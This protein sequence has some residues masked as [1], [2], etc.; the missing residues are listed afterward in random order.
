MIARRLGIVTSAGL[1]TLTMVGFSGLVVW[2]SWTTARHDLEHAE[3]ERL[4]AIAATLALEIPADLHR[5]AAARLPGRDA[6]RSWAQAPPQLRRLRER[7]V[8]AVRVN[9]LPSPIYTLEMPQRMRARIAA[10][11]D[12]RWPGALQFI[13]TTAE[14]PY[15]RHRCDYRAEMQVAWFL[16]RTAATP[17]YR[18][19][20]GSWVSAF[21]PIRDARGT[22]VALLEVDQPLDALLATMRR[23]L[24]WRGLLLAAYFITTLAVAAGFVRHIRATERR[25]REAAEA[26]ARARTAFL[27]NMSHE[28]RTPLTAILGYAETL[29]EPDLPERERMRA[30]RILH[31]NGQHLLRIVDDILDMSRIE[32][33]RLAVERI[34][35]N[36]VQI[37]AEV[38]SLMR[39]R[40][41]ARQLSLRFHARGRLPGT[42][43]S[44]P[45]RLR[46]ILL[47][48]VGNAIKFTQRGGVEVS[49][50]VVGA[51]AAQP[52]LKI[53]VRDSGIGMNAEQLARVFEPFAQ[54]DESTTRR[55]GGTGLG[56]AISRRL[57]RQLGGDLTA[58]STPGRGSCFTLT[59]P[60]GPLEGVAWVTVPTEA[61]EQPDEPARPE[62]RWG[63]DCALPKGCRILLAEDA[64]DT[65]RLVCRFLEKGGATVTAVEDGQ[66]AVEQALAAARAGRPF[67]AVLMD[68]QMPV[69][70]GYGATRALREAGYR[71]TIIALTAH[72]MPDDRQRCLRAGCDDYATKPI[73][74][75]VLFATLR[76]H[77]DGQA[78][79]SRPPATTSS[80]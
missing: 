8:Q 21:A 25:R 54:A 80:A 51:H 72:A 26:G 56:L 23:R 42:I 41:A 39:L 1:L 76:R 30:A 68:M 64:P 16:G 10:Q 62:E 58:Q 49:A 28:I 13:L 11:P 27:A 65:R 33:G 46:Q 4:K 17:I 66:Q 19:A 7:L 57:A 55:F 69:L 77:L 12:R 3:R 70:D 5:R 79:S 18:D 14:A 78:R 20:H 67:D 36:P 34:A 74:R 75:E 31:R 44:D 35:C 32:S 37:L 29:S 52:V 43:R 71:G 59:I 60:T 47:N 15:W 6:L 48:L 2:V 38:H 45:T 9:H 22:T 53:Q 24:A 63:T 61:L 50:E 40:A 73:R